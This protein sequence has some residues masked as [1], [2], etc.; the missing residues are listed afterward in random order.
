[1]NRKQELIEELKNSGTPET[2]I[3]DLTNAKQWTSD[4]KSEFVALV[5]DTI[6]YL[7]SQPMLDDEGMKSLQNAKYNMNYISLS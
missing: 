3:N 1:M 2:I 7:S 6:G 4:E 5:S